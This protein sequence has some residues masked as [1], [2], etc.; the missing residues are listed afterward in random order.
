MMT[1]ILDSVA[2]DEEEV[3]SIE[4]INFTNLII[5]EVQLFIFTLRWVVF[6]FYGFK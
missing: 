1:D 5:N 2:G 6:E 3:D 4:K